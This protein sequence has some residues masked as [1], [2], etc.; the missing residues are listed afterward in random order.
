MGAV[1]LHT[2]ELMVLHMLSPQMASSTK[3]HGLSYQ[4]LRW[5]MRVRMTTQSSGKTIS[6]TEVP[7]SE[8]RTN[9][10]NAV[11]DVPVG[12]VEAAALNVLGHTF[13]IGRSLFLEDGGRIGRI[14]ADGHSFLLKDRK[15]F[16]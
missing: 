14:N 9:R 6:V 11:G 12:V 3:L 5:W 8:F 7:L 4:V 15:V 16:G 13:F 10:L 1:L 2:A